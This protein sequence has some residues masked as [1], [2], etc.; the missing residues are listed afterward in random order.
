[1][2]FA[3]CFALLFDDG[4]V[5]FFCFFYPFVLRLLLLKEKS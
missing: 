4:N 5:L 3:D 1:L 2:L